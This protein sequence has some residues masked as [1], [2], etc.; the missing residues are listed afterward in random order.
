MEE[1]ASDFCFSVEGKSKAIVIGP[2]SK[3][4]FAGA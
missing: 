3:A 1:L 4:S 2:D